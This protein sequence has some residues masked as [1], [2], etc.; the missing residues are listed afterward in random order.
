MA[1]SAPSCRT[2]LAQPYAIECSWAMPTTSARLSCRTGRGTS[3]VIIFSL[4]RRKVQKEAARE[5]VGSV[6]IVGGGSH[7]VL[8]LYRV[9]LEVRE[10]QTDIALALVAGIVDGHEETLAVLPLPAPGDEAVGGPV[11]VPGGGA[12]DLAPLSIPDAC[13]SP[14]RQEAV[15]ELLQGPVDG[16]ARSANQVRRDTLAPSLE[17]PLVEESQARRQ[18]RDDGRGLVHPGR[19][20]RGGPGLVVVLHEA[21]EPVLVVETRPQVLSHGPRVSLAQT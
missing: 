16:L 20:R 15:V 10:R 19:K 12:R 4:S 8:E 17:L 14:H 6:A 13:S 9:A 11:A 21:R 18:V 5:D 1:S 2:A 3:V 7:Q